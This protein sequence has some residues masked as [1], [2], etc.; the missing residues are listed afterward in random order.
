MLL[1]AMIMDPVRGLVC[2][3]VFCSSYKTDEREKPHA[4]RNADAKQ[5]DKNIEK[6]PRKTQ[7][8]SP[9][10]SDSSAARKTKSKHRE[11]G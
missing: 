8:S 10:C 7:T 11:R 9:Q 6:H 2:V 4:K 3:S 5:C 1:K